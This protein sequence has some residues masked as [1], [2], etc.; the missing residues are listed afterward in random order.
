MNI[1]K[2]TAGV[3]YLHIPV[4]GYSK[5]YLYHV[6]KGT[7]LGVFFIYIICYSICFFG[8]LLFGKTWLKNLFV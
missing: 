7:F 5:Y 2:Y 1:T 4:Y 6:R 3:Y 8:M